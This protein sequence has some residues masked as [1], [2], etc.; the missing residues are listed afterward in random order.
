MAIVL[1]AVVVVGVAAIGLSR[2]GHSRPTA[3]AGTTP[4]ATLTLDPTTT[5]S[6]PRTTRRT[7]TPPPTTTSRRTT[8]TS[9]PPTTTLPAG[10]RPV[11]KLGD[12]PLFDVGGLPATN[13]KLT[14]WTTDQAGA[15][16]F[17]RSALP[18]L[19]SAWEPVLKAA[20]LPFASPTL[21]FPGGTVWNS[22]CG[23]EDAANGRVAAF[24]CATNTTIYM[25]FNAIQTDL[26]GA[27]PGVYLALFAHEYG[28]HVQAM[29]GMEDAY[30]KVTYTARSD[31]ERQE[32]SRRLELQAQCFSGMFLAATSG[33]GDVDGNIT[34]EA[35]TSQDRGD[36]NG[37][38]RDHGTDNHTIGW[39][40]SG[41]QRN[42]LSQCDTWSASSA[43][44]A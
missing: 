28:H 31:D 40:N 33:R 12:N 24:Y 23:S 21:A 35:E 3:D 34:R 1:V 20:G 25:P 44:V 15:E 43:D 39:W 29:S 27:H 6:P 16:R 9:A 42:S 10:P 41:F 26:Y 32:L 18:C 5:T 7:T 4:T 37:P 14:R 17:F 11:A 2:L 13:C 36:H 19:D 8:T 38:P 30:L 22:P